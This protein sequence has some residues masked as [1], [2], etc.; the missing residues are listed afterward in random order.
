MTSY[1]IG[2]AQLRDPKVK[3]LVRFSGRGWDAFAQFKASVEQKLNRK[4][5]EAVAMD[6]LLTRDVTPYINKG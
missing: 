1:V 5:S 3:R 2:M 4:V 6:V